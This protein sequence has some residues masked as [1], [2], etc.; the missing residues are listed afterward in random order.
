MQP[1]AALRGSLQSGGL[2][3]VASQWPGCGP[4]QCPLWVSTFCMTDQLCSHIHKPN[5][6]FKWAWVWLSWRSIAQHMSGLHGVPPALPSTANHLVGLVIRSAI[7]LPGCLIVTGSPQHD[8][9][10]ASSRPGAAGAAPV[11]QPGRRG[12]IRGGGVGGKERFPQGMFPQVRQL[13][14]GGSARTIGGH[15]TSTL[16]SMQP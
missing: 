16:S 5:A 9:K 3:P 14:A 6:K 4:A 12:G 7:L 15:P 1:L 2:A 11:R 8:T 13:G 10:P